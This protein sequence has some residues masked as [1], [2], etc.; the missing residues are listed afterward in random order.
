MP[1]VNCA[2][3][4]IRSFALAPWSTVNP[5]LAARRRSR[6]LARASWKTCASPRTGRN[7]LRF[8]ASWGAPRRFRER[9]EQVPDAAAEPALVRLPAR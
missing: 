1:H 9:A 2:S 6:C 8:I 4:G 3:C 5:A 7:P